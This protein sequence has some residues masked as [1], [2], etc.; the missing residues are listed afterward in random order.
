MKINTDHLLSI[1]DLGKDEITELMERA[2][3]LK[4]EWPKGNRPRPLA[5]K[6]VA[7]IFE[8]PSTRTRV[9]FEVAITQLGGSPLFMTSR[10]S[11]LARSEPL[12]DTAR[13]LSRYVDAVVVRTFG[14]GVVESLAKFGSIPVINALTDLYHP[15]Q[16][17][18]DL[19]TVKENKGDPRGLSFCWLG[20]GNNMAHSWIEAA[21]RL[22]FALSLACPLGYL[23]DEDIL[24]H[25]KS[26]GADI[27]VTQDPEEAI[28]GCDVVST[29]VWASM[30]Q[31]D[32]ATERMK[33]FA[34]YS[35]DEELLAKAAPDAMVLHCLPA[36]RG[37][38]ISEAVL[39]GLQ[40]VVWDQA[41]NRL[42]M[43]KAILEALLEG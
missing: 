23:P 41:E 20:D 1:R 17:L 22:G 21:A 7:L 2:A 39:E 14:H 40:S 3:Y 35:L 25:A 26:L 36:H 38:E 5:D 30:G 43:Q 33:I 6:T 8:K 32:E 18:S 37:E 12:R 42:H 19:L 29:D 27:T 4:A 31:E 16:V 11:Q 24:G 9:S 34:P 13:V 28:S 10:D 15:C